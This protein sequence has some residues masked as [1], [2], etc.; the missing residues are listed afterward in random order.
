MKKLNERNNDICKY[1][2][3]Y[4]QM[5]TFSYYSSYSVFDVVIVVADIQMKWSIIENDIRNGKRYKHE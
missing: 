4:I 5:Y 2:C 3:T 1:I